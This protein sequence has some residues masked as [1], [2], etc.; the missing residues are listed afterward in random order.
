MLVGVI[1]AANWTISVGHIPEEITR[2][3][4][5]EILK[6]MVIQYNT[7]QDNTEFI[8]FMLNNKRHINCI[9]LFSSNN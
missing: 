2:F 8:N 1:K 5:N 4:G 3:I 6:Q 9:N 7:V